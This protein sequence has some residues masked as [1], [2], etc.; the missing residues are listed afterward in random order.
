[1]RSK[2]MGEVCV[3]RVLCIDIGTVLT[4]HCCLLDVSYSNFPFALCTP[5]APP[6]PHLAV[7]AD[8]AAGPALP[9]QLHQRRLQRPL[10]RCVSMHT[11]TPCQRLWGRGRWEGGGGGRQES[12]SQSVSISFS[13]S[14][15]EL[16]RLATLWRILGKP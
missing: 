10:Q 14:T 2:V 5:A 6:L 9:H 11:R 7:K 16:Y 3:Q 8:V 12:H 4:V 15:D 13:T 1:M